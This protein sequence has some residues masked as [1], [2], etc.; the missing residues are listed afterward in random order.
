LKKGNFGPRLGA[1]YR[2]TGQTILSAGYGMVWIEMAGITT[3]FTTPTFPFL[4]TVSQRALDTINPAFVLQN[5]PSV[6]PISPT[7]TA[8][9]GQGVF[10]VDGT[11]G[12]GYVQQWNVSVQRELTTN[13][14]FEA[15]YVGS[16]ITHVGIPD[17][18]V[19]Q[20]TVD[21]LAQGAPLLQRVP[22]P[23]FGIIPRSSSL[24]DPTITVAQLLKPYPAYTTVSFYRNNVGT[25]RYN[26]LELSVRQRLA[27]GVSYSVAYTRSKLVDDA[28]SVFDASI[29]T[30]PIANYPVADSFN[31]A[32]ERDYSTGDMPH[33]FV[34]SAVWDL[35]FGS[36]RSRQLHGVAGVLASDWT[37]TGLVTL[38]SGMPVAVTQATNF[39][40]FAGFGVQRPNLVGDPTLPADQRTPAQWFNTA[41]FAIAPQFTIGSASRN[42]VRGPSYRDIDFAVMRRVPL[43]GSDRAFEFRVE[44]FNL[45]NTVNLGAPATVAGAANF[46][47]ITTALDPRIVQLALKFLF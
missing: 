29:L 12:S 9:L 32:L 33:V 19:N 20:L 21:Q 16:N 18:N 2:V 3:P 8:G 14:T 10:T 35:P 23:Y 4:Q 37:V 13:T 34:S 26:G 17:T 22:N 27:H 45:L 40:A 24:G 36:R 47:T 15:A 39:N 41:A 7:P 31:R 42:P 44:M 11:L 30:G 6:A 5:G 38:Q 28:S 46:G 43:A 25:T 1:V